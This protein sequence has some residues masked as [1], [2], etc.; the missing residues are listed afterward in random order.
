MRR[1]LAR[2]YSAKE[3]N[4]S[5]L[6]EKKF[7]LQNK[8]DD[9]KDKSKKKISEVKVDLISKWE[10]KSNDLIKHFLELFGRDNIKGFWDKSR[11]GLMKAISPP[12][13]PNRSDSDDPEMADDTDSPP[14]KRS[15][16]INELSLNLTS[17]SD[18]EDYEDFLTPT[19]SFPAASMSGHIYSQ[20]H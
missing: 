8:F 5:F 2:G 6:S 3:L 16:R 10:E 18:E 13:S 9:F 20:N 15:T 19:N 1:N 4:V 14:A 7:R 11:R 12:A 17:E